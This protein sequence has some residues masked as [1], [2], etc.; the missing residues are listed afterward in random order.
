[1]ISRASLAFCEPAKSLDQFVTALIERRPSRNLRRHGSKRETRSFSREFKLEAVRRIEAGE[2]V[3]ALAREL[4]IKRAILYRWRDAHR[5]G[6]PEA[7][8]L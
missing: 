2:N 3:S 4:V 5:L 8:R 1:M 6:G 7:L